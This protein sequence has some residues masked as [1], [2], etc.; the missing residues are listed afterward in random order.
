MLLGANLL[1]KMLTGTGIN[2]AG[3]GI[4]RAGY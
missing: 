3:E 4:I 1:E 2:T